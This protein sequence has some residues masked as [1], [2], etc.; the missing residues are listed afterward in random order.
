M[1]K[2]HQV[3]S[4][5]VGAILGVAPGCGGDGT[6][7]PGEAAGSGGAGGTGGAPFD[8]V[9]LELTDR[10]V[11]EGGETTANRDMSRFASVEVQVLAEGA[12]QA[13]AGALS[14]DG[15]RWEIPDVPEGE[16]WLVTTT[17]PDERAEGAPSSRAMLQTTARTVDFGRTFAGRPDGGEATRDI[18]VALTADGLTPWHQVGL[19]ADGSGVQPLQ[20]SIELYSFNVDALASIEP[21][22]GD[23]GAPAD[24]GTAFSG[25]TFNWRDSVYPSSHDGE[26]PLVDGSRGD[27]LHVTQLVEHQVAPSAGQADPRDPWSSFTYQAAEASFSTREMTLQDGEAAVLGGAFAPLALSSFAADLRISQF[28]AQVT[29]HAPAALS[30]TITSLSLYQEPGSGVPI[31]GMTPTLLRAQVVSGRAPADATCFPEEGACDPQLCPDGCNDALITFHPG[32]HVA[33]YAYGNPYA[34]RGME[35]ADVSVLFRTRVTHPVEARQEVLRGFVSV[36]MRAE[37]ANGAAMAPLLGLPRD[38][39]LDGKSLPADA[40]T[41]GTGATPTLT[42][43]PPDVGAADGY[44]VGIVLHDDLKDADGAVLSERSMVLSADITGTTFKV[45]EGVLES[46]RYYSVQV[47]AYLGSHTREAPSRYNGATLARAQSYTGMFTP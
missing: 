39:R 26:V 11:T 7:T 25:W 44:Q 12:V 13:F 23:T 6:S 42:F 45:P 17:A 38:L 3:S 33:T 43:E 36:I 30:S 35:L 47:A 27:V 22:E 14:A 41:E 37:D 18:E 32:D 20:D 28:I 15:A 46:G 21:G 2:I 1:R 9:I 34:P 4:M 24:G 10:Y 40:V 16:Y 31:Y 19:E 8:G 5:L 29:A